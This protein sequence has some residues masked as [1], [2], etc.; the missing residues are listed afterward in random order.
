MAYFVTGATGFIGR[1]LVERLLKREGDINVLV[2]ERS[3]PKLDVLL[4]RWAPGAA[5]RIHPVTG[6]LD[7]P[8][9]GVGD[10]TAAALAG[11]IDHFFH[12]AA[13]YDITVADDTN[14]IANVE[15]TRHAVELA[16][17]LQVGRFHHMSSIAVAGCAPACFAR[18]CST[19]AGSSIIRITG[20]SSR[21]RR[22]RARRPRCPGACTAPR[23]SS[24]TR[25]PARWTRS[26]G[27]TTSSPRSPPT[28][29]P[30]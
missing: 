5:A 13:I 20:P 27:P 17:A 7:E 6:D 24:V 25:R 21:P 12:L 9:L 30:T 2:R 11:G 8:R 1:R 15:G 23:S 14:A 26:T 18:T 16:N 3:L 10:E 19:R 22:S 4:E 29:R 28:S